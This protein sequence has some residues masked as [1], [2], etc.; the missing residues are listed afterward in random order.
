MKT[1]PSYHFVDLFFRKKKEKKLVQ[2]QNG[3]CCDCIR[4]GSIRWS[5]LRGPQLQIG[6]TN[7]SG[8]ST[9]TWSTDKISEEGREMHASRCRQSVGE[10]MLPYVSAN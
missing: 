4:G 9:L 8:L 2:Y 1:V 5:P 3:S 6:D 7:L 10:W